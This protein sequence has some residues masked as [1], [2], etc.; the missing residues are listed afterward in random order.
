M[1]PGPG[2]Q[3]TLL[4]RRYL[5]FLA[6][7]TT[8][9]GEPLPYEAILQ[10]ICDAAAQTVADVS[11]M[12]L[13]DETAELQVFAAAHVI[14]ER[15]ERLRRRAIELLD[16]PKGP[17]WWFESVI[18]QGQGLL[19]PQVDEPTI[20]S[21]GGNPAYVSFIRDLGVRSFL[22]VPLVAQG[23]VLGALSL[24]YT[25]HSGLRYD[26]DALVL[27]ED[28]GRRIG[29]VIGQAKV[30]ETAIGVST[31][32]QHVALP[33][34]LPT[35][36][37]LELDSLYETAAS[38]LLIGGDWYDAFVLPEGRLGLSIGDISGHGIEAAAFMSSL[39]NA[40]RIAMYLESD[41]RK[42][43]SAADELMKQS[44]NA[45]VFATANISIVDVRGHTLSCTA[46]GHPG[47]L[48]WSER[49]HAVAD[50]FSDRGLPLGF[51]DL[52]KEDNATQTV[53]FEPGDFFVF[54][55]DGLLEGERDY[56]AGEARLADVMAQRS[57]RESSRPAKAIR[58]AVAPERH[59]DDLAVLTLHIA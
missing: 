33:K 38:E 34:S 45:D 3:E 25:D 4:E 10:R 43:L 59:P 7:V 52:A 26:R 50:P 37:G 29:A 42:V 13:Y 14:G 48:W 11:T 18:R 2:H 30:H 32:F 9:L 56:L 5:T 12:H 58:F 8:L 39:R 57:V 6:E 28:L 47:P 15:S 1:R 24:V 40:L 19:I 16:D 55:T 46:A 27:A 51:R 23:G 21:A 36:P 31:S 49:S 54:F 17:R 41:M 22:I 35:I 44:T 20:D 53:Q